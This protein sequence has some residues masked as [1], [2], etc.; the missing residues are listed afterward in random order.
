VRAP[1]PSPPSPRA[2]EVVAD[3]PPPPPPS[4]VT[5]AP[6]SSPRTLARADAALSRAP[7]APATESRDRGRLGLYLMSG[8]GSS[9]QGNLIVPVVVGL[10]VRW[11]LVALTM[12]G[13]GGLWSSGFAGGDLGVML[14]HAFGPVLLGG[15]V[16][17]GAVASFADRREPVAV[18]RGYLRAGWATRRSFDLFAQLEFEYG[19][20]LT[21]HDNVEGIVLNVG[22]QVR[23]L[24]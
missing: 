8:A 20:G 18:A 2:A 15:G 7:G 6:E 19:R 24:P 22:F 23:L 9:L 5:A 16:A 1:L 17:G 3:A 12:E 21:S 11:R 14:H 4:T 10:A 13:L